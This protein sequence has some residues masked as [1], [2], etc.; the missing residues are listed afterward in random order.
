[1]RKKNVY[2][3]LNYVASYLLMGVFTFPAV[4]IILTAIRPDKEVNAS[5]PVWIPETV[6]FDAF[7]KLF[8]GN[9]STGSI[10]FHD[11]FLNT[12]WIALLSTV[13]SVMIGTLA[14][15]YFS[16]HHSKRANAVFLSMMLARAIPGVALSLPLFLVFSKIGV[17]DKIS[18]LVIAYTA[19]NIPFATWLMQ[20][21]FKEISIELDEAS[22]V[23]GCSMWGSFAKIAL[24]LTLPGL[25]AAAIFTFLTVWGE[26]QIS[27]LLAR[28]VASKPFTVGLF[29]FTTQFTVDWRGMAAMAVVMIIP[30]TLF[31]IVAQKW[32]IRGLTF[33]A[34]K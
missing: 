29:D 9:T 23:D 34:S 22:F 17:L 27:S 7:A 30:S 12:I 26:F 11:Y 25:S 8:G 16:R 24:P 14:G 15:Y 28:T 19:L 31:V 2:L 4:W 32:L 6:T 1:M 3:S 33:G 13:F 10:P 5:P 20:G 18:G 21:F